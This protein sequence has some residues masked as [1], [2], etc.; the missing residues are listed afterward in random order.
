MYWGSRLAYIVLKLV[1]DELCHLPSL[2]SSCPLLP[3]HQPALIC[4]HGNRGG[5]RTDGSRHSVKRRGRG[6]WGWGRKR[7]GRG[8]WT[9]ERVEKNKRG[10]DTFRKL[11]SFWCLPKTPVCGSH[12]DQHYTCR[13]FTISVH[14]CLYIIDTAHDYNWNWL[15]DI[16]ITIHSTRGGGRTLIQCASI[17]DA[18]TYIYIYIV[19]VQSSCICRCTRPMSQT[20]HTYS[21]LMRANKL[22]TAA[23]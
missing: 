8:R 12:K 9:E 14:T 6:R 22:E 1:H 23:L 10:M 13:Y 11:P 2:S 21:L 3:R 17:E 19:Y 5:P 18:A 20:S 7:G 4:P 15:Y 16:I